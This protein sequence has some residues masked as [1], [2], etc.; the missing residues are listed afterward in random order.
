[1]EVVCLPGSDGG[2]QQHFVLEAV[3][4]TSMYFNNLDSTRSTQDLLD[5]EIST[6][7]DQV[8]MIFPY[9]SIR[10]LEGNIKKNK[11]KK[12][13]RSFFILKAHVCATNFSWSSKVYVILA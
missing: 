9:I 5:N 1:L 8:S 7:N 13:Q 10:M 12:A 3:G 2:L 6:M 4:A 11:E